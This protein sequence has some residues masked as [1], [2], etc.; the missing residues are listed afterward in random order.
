[1]SD[2]KL[3]VRKLKEFVEAV[4]ADG[5]DVN[6]EVLAERKAVAELSLEELSKVCGGDGETVFLNGIE[7]CTPTGG[8]KG[9]N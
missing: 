9:E 1:M 3:F 4:P 7:P 2:L 6:W 8:P 5:E